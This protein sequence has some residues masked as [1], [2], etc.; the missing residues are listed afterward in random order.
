MVVQVKA[1]KMSETISRSTA[2]TAILITK[3]MRVSAREQGYPG[4]KQISGHEW[5]E[6]NGAVL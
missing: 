5:I 6:A 4:V 3:D 1:V 2:R